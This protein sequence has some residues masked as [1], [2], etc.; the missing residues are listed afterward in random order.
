MSKPKL[1]STNDFPRGK[2]CQDD[3][4]GLRIAVYESDKTVIINFGKDIEWIGLDKETAL[5]LANSLMEC[6]AKI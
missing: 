2:L 6:A 1:G 4:G 3:E 5:K